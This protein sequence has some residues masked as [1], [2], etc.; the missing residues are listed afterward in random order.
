MYSRYNIAQSA[1]IPKELLAATEKEY[2][3][4]AASTDSSGF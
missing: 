1:N 2:I 4:S 3:V